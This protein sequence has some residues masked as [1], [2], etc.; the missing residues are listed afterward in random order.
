MMRYILLFGVFVFILFLFN[1]REYFTIDKNDC[2]PLYC[3]Q[4][5]A[6]S[7]VKEDVNVVA[8]LLINV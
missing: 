4:A 3:S 7:T 5:G 6:T 8:P 1:K 2:D